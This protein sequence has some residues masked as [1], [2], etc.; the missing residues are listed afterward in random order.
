MKN[1]MLALV[2][3]AGFAVILNA[4]NTTTP[5]VQD[6]QIDQ[7]TT[8]QQDQ[9]AF[10]SLVDPFVKVDSSGQFV[11]DSQA[12]KSLNTENLARAGQYLKA[13]N[14]QIAG[15]LL[16]ANADLSL[17]LPSAGLSTL[18]NSNGWKLYWWG[19]RLALDATRTRKVIAALAV[20][21]GT[22]TLISLIPFPPTAVGGKIV[23]A[24]LGI[25]AGALSYC[26]APGYGVY[27]YRSWVGAS[28]CRSQP[29]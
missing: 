14:E 19:F 17:S 13:V 15:G 22:S 18:A 9:D 29:R 7:N 6:P 12:A 8:V 28:W 25:G 5:Q 4:C 27:I 24:I 26:N 21:A 10:V 2:I 23:A 3:A 11:L 1:R 20:G 16:V